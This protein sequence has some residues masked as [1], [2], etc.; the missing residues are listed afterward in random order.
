MSEEDC[1]KRRHISETDPIARATE[2][3]AD[4]MQA[5]HTAVA[6]M[7][8]F[9]DRPDYGLATRQDCWKLAPRMMA[10]QVVAAN[11]LKRL[12]KGHDG[13]TATDA[14]QGSPSRQKMK[15]TVPAQPVLNAGDEADHAETVDGS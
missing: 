14:D 7:H 1:A 5:T 10:A 6:Y 3:L 15:T 9:P 8:K 12:S 13:V 2:K 4:E 11:A